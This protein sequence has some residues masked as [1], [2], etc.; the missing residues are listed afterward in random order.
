LNVVRGRRADLVVIL[1]AAIGID[2]SELKAINALGYVLP[3]LRGPGIEVQVKWQ[4]KEGSKLKILHVF[5]MLLELCT[6]LAM[7][8][9]GFWRVTKGMN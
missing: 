9:L 2:R 1:E 7:Y 4:E 3:R 6:I 5:H 8:R